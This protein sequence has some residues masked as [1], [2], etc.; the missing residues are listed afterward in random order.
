MAGERPKDWCKWIPLAEWWYNTTFHSATQT[1]PYEVVYGQPAPIYLPY[2]PGDSN[3]EAI[4]R[5]LQTRKA[6]IKLL[7]FHLGRAQHR[8]KVQANKGRSD[9]VFQI[10]DF[11]Y[12]KL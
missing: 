5:S 9:R 10:G 11:V 3:V 12:V 2:F 8:M 4:D 7:K 6:V 1:T